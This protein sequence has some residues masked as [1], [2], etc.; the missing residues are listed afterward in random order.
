MSYDVF[1]FDPSIAPAER[2]EF[3]AWYDDVVQWNGPHDY[4]DPARL[5]QNLRA[6]YDALRT[7]FPPMNGPHADVL[8]W[9]DP[10]QERRLAEYSMTSA[11]IYIAFAPS[12]TGE[13][14]AAV[15]EAAGRCGVG[16]LMVSD[17]EG[18]IVRP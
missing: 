16:V 8:S 13:A 14:R 6:F 10:E 9:E 11:A 12:V 1:V 3:M 5:G 15:L 2:R 17:V 4:S 7:R 18:R